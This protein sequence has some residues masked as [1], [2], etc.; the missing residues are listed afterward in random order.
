VDTDPNCLA[1]KRYELKLSNTAGGV[2]EFFIQGDLSTSLSLIIKLK[3]EYVFPTEPVHIAAE[4]AKIRFKLAPWEEAIN[5][6]L[7]NLPPVVILQT[8]RGSLVVSY[9][10]DKTCF[11][12]CSAPEV[13]PSSSI[14]RPC[15]MDRL[16][17]FAYPKSYILISYQMAPGMGALKGSEILEFFDWAEEKEKFVLATACDCHGVFHSFRKQVA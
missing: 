12:K 1:V 8:G 11:E 17:R 15:S 14:K 9:N 13:C 10:R 7:P 2:G 3:P 6:I 16:M 5:C 4:L